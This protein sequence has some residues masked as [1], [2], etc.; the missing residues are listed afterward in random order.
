MDSGKTRV[1]GER[2]E[3]ESETRAEGQDGR[4][5]GGERR[6]EPGRWGGEDRGVGETVEGRKRENRR[7]KET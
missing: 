2:E 5:P 7:R 3:T 6:E 4:G 1:D